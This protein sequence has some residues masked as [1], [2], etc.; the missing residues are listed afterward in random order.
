MV[1][2]SSPHRTNA[3]WVAIEARQLAD[4]DAA[5][6]RDVADA[7]AAA[8]ARTG[9]PGAK[10]EEL[11]MLRELLDRTTDGWAKAEAIARELRH[12]LPLDV[13]GVCAELK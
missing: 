11:R 8:R 6:V 3:Q 2:T 4:A 10:A 9:D 5:D 12:D 13:E 7:I 1:V